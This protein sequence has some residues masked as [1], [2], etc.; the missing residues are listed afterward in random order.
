[1]FLGPSKSWRKIRDTIFTEN[2]SYSEQST[3]NFLARRSVLSQNRLRDEQETRAVP[4][5][6][7]VRAE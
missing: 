7:P 4:G 5:I 3:M 6:L 1:M 2:L